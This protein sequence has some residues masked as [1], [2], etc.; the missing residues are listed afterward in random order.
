MN[1]KVIITKEHIINIFKILQSLRDIPKN[2]IEELSFVNYTFITKK[3][4]QVSENKMRIKYK[5]ILNLVCYVNSLNLCVCSVRTIGLNTRRESWKIVANL[6]NRN[7]GK[8]SK[9]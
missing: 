1:L 2:F 3:I 8:L 6:E 5:H 9:H 7:T 4:F